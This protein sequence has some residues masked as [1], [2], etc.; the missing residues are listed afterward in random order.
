MGSNWDNAPY[1][2]TTIG[3]GFTVASIPI[4]IISGNQGRR[5]VA[6]SIQF[7]TQERNNKNAKRSIGCSYPAILMKYSFKKSINHNQSAHNK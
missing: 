6:A 1:I 5:G 2:T 3:I 4:F 7:S